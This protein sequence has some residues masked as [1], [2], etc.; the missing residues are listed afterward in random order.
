MAQAD[1]LLVTTIEAVNAACLAQGLP[2]LKAE[3][4]RHSLEQA[5]DWLGEGGMLVPLCG[6]VCDANDAMQAIARRGDGI[7]ITKGR[8][9]FG[10]AEAR[11]RFATALAGIGRL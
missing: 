5:L 1:D 6:T 10:V 3:E 8:V 9:E 7:A 2:P 11:A 4:A